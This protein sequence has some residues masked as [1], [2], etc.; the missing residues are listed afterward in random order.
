MIFEKLFQVCLPSLHISLGVFFKIFTLFE[1]EVH[2][3]DVIIALKQ[4][5]LSSANASGGG[6][7]QYQAYIAN[8][9]QI[10]ELHRKAD[11]LEDEADFFDELATWAALDN[12]ET[13]GSDGQLELLRGQANLAR[14][15][16]TDL[17]RYPTLILT[18]RPCN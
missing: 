18:Y 7:D 14:R 13:D 6:G 5:S 17:V 12:Q 4:S 8:L 15:K 3:I 2:K 11:E 1:E 16:A 10:T 9:R